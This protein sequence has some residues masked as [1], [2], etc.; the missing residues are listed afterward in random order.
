MKRFVTALLPQFDARIW[1]WARN[2]IQDYQVAADVLTPLE[3][4]AWTAD[5]VLQTAHL[6]KRKRREAEEAQSKSP[7]TNMMDWLQLPLFRNQTL[8]KTEPSVSTMMDWLQLPLFR[9]QTLLTTAKVHHPIPE[10]KP[11]NSTEGPRRPPGQ[12]HGYS[13]E[14]V[15]DFCIVALV[16][17]LALMVAFTAGR[18]G[19]KA[20]R[21]AEGIPIAVIQRL[22]SES[23]DKDEIIS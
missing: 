5:V 2:L 19:K 3:V 21:E 9:N 1:D 18:A 14:D 13:L 17:V 15:F 22:E 23:W 12:V 11:R 6:G 16:F 4:D 8:L 10:P 7:V 20:Q